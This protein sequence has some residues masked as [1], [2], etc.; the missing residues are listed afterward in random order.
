VT[1][2]TVQSAKYPKVY[3]KLY[4]IPNRCRRGRCVEELENQ[5]RND[6]LGR[7][8]IRIISTIIWPKRAPGEMRDTAY[9]DAE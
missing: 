8:T 5:K 7:C 9:G 2:T 4:R 6:K 1:K 3:K